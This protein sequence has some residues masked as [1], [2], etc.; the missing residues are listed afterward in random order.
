MYMRAT[1]TYSASEMTP[2]QMVCAQQFI[3]RASKVF[4][5]NSLCCAHQLCLARRSKCPS[6]KAK[7]ALAAAIEGDERSKVQHGGET[8]GT[9]PFRWP[10]EQEPLMALFGDRDGQIDGP[11]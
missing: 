9:R 6:R 10:R 4:A 11:S 2:A 5:R 3:L 1:R 8:H 7:E